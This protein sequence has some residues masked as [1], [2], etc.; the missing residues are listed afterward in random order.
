MA[1]QV[2]PCIKKPNLEP[3][4]VA[5]YRPISN[6]CFLS[7][8]LERAVLP[9]LLSHLR[10]NNLYPKFQSAYRSCHSTET[11]LL[12]VHNDLLRVVDEG[13]E[14]LVIPL[15]FSSAFDTIDHGILI[16]RLQ[17]R[18]GF[19]G[20]VLSW[21]TSYLTNR[22]QCISINHSCSSSYGI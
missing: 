22:T 14:A 12:R 13:N 3:N 17:N 21:F 15:D 5:N 6:L 8:L 9:Q 19:S 7:K 2:I 10:S 20:T 4:D 18:Y 11:A 1:A 16:H